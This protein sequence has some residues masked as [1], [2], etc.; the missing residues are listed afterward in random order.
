MVLDLINS[1][2]N[3]RKLEAFA[4]GNCKSSLLVP[5]GYPKSRS[6][7]LE[8]WPRAPQAHDLRWLG[9]SGRLKTS[10]TRSFAASPSDCPWSDSTAVRRSSA[11]CYYCC[12]I[13]NCWSDYFAGCYDAKATP[14]ITCIEKSACRGLACYSRCSCPGKWSNW[15]SYGRESPPEV[16]NPTLVAAHRQRAHGE[17]WAARQK[18]KLDGWRACDFS[19]LFLPSFN[20]GTTSFN[21][22][23]YFAHSWLEKIDPRGPARGITA[24]FAQLSPWEAAYAA[25]AKEAVVACASW[26]TGCGSW[27]SW[28]RDRGDLA[29]FLASQNFD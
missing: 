2:A 9:R 14:K 10:S 17:C 23:D 5:L 7:G 11:C 15:Q 21:F 25:G 4:E 1:E 8:L 12:D 29:R 27:P 20:W 24:C 3:L 6:S 26:P 19:W 16:S 13:A 18:L 22:F 28:L